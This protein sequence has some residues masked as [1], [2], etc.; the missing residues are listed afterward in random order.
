MKLLVRNNRISVG[1]G[2]L[3][4]IYESVREQQFDCGHVLVRGED[5]NDGER[6]KKA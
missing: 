2:Q 6:S 5:R 1:S 4:L 3:W